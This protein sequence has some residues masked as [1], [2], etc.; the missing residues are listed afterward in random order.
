MEYIM[1]CCQINLGR[2]SGR[3]P[4]FR[5]TIENKARKI[6]T[7]V[8]EILIER[9]NNDKRKADFL[10]DVVMAEKEIYKR[11][12]ELKDMV[13]RQTKSL[14]EELSVIKSKHLK[15]ME[16]RR[17]EIDMRCTILRSFEAY[18]TEL[19]SKGSASDICSSLDQLIVGASDL[20]RDQEAFF[21]C[22]H[23]SIDVTFQAADLGDALQKANNNFVGNVHGNIFL[24]TTFRPTF[25]CLALGSK[26]LFLHFT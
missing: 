8:N 7:Y 12:Q 4:K 11:N 20:E 6:S 19:T 26:S 22:P 10:K 16:T 23:Q 14:L 15:E 5:Q 24:P 13:D 3:L 1:Y 17:E 25:N 2:Y 21:G 9:N 18:C